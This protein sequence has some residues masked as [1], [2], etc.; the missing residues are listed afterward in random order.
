[1]PPFRACHPVPLLREELS[2]RARGSFQTLECGAAGPVPRWGAPTGGAPTD[3][4]ERIAGYKTPRS[5]E[6]VEGLPVSAAGKVLKREL[7]KP[8]WENQES[9]VH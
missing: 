7:R 9:A 4:A 3:C 1:M 5:M 6:L 2:G 8:Y